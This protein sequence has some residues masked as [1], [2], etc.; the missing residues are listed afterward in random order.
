ME[1]LLPVL[2]NPRSGLTAHGVCRALERVDFDDQALLTHPWW[3]WESWPPVNP[4]GKGAG[5]RF[6][7]EHYLGSRKQFPSL[8]AKMYLIGLGHE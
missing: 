5:Y 4:Y 1:L 2:E 7:Y 6:V 8:R 3:I